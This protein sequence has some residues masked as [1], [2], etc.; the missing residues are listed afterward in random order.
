MQLGNW[1]PRSATPGGR[2]AGSAREPTRRR[3]RAVA[4]AIALAIT[5]GCAQRPATEATAQFAATLS[6][7][8]SAV[9]AS[10]ANIGR[11][12]RRLRSLAAANVYLE[13]PPGTTRGPAVALPDRG[14]TN[15]DVARGVLTPGLELLTEYARHLTYLT[16]ADSTAPLRRSTDTLRA[17]LGKG[18]D[19]LG[20]ALELRVP[21][22]VVSTGKTASDVLLTLVEAAVEQQ[23]ARNLTAVVDQ[24]DEP[25]RRIAAL[26]KAVVGE[27]ERQGLRLALDTINRDAELQ[28]R[29]ILAQL[30]SDRQVSLL[31]RY[32]AFNEIVAS[33]DQ[34]ASLALLM[35]LNTAVDSMVRAHGALR[36]PAE[37]STRQSLDSFAAAVE[38][39]VAIY[40]RLHALGR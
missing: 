11:A 40:Q 39:L 1:M 27:D 13:L 20:S 37:A 24:A 25:V 8:A 22:S 31:A 30:R 21:P 5:A 4:F 3:N 7:A 26:L 23:I 29:L 14:P 9:D 12:E 28:R 17:S 18:L 10:L 33:R 36:R 32:E 6:T 19:A 34:D 15:A 16:S 38:R 35:Q 2:A